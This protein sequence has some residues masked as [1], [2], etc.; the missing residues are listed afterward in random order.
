MV[1]HRNLK[2]STIMTRVLM[3]DCLARGKGERRA[4]LDVVGVGPRSIVGVLER[5][6]IESRIMVFEELA[7]NPAVMLEYDVLMVSAMSSDKGCAFKALR[8]WKEFGR[9]PTIIGGPIGEEYTLL[10]EKGFDLVVVGEGEKVVEKLLKLGLRDSILPEVGI[11]KEIQGL[12]FKHNDNVVFTGRGPRLSSHDL[13]FYRPST[14]RIIDYPSYWGLRIYV[15]V[16]RGCSNFYRPKIKFPSGVKCIDCDICRSGELRQRLTCPVN[17]PP[18]CGYCSVPALY[19][20]SR[21]KPIDAVYREV[22]ELIELGATR[23]VLS[24][25]DFLDYGRDWLVEPDPLTDPRS[26]PPNIDAI[27]NLLERLWNISEVSSGE[28]AI[29]I[30]NIKANLVNEEVASLLGEYLKGTPVHIG[31]ETGSIEH[32]LAIGRP[33]TPNECIKAVELLVKHGLRP[34]LYFIHGLPGQTLDTAYETIKIMEEA[35]S[36]GAEKITVYRFSP[37]PGTAFEQFPPGPPAH[38]NPASSLIYSKATELNKMYKNRLIGKNIEA[39]VV[40]RRGSYGVAYPFYHGPVILV[41]DG[42]RF[43]GYLAK[44]K[45]TKVISD[46]LVEG[47]VLRV[48]RRIEKTSI[49]KR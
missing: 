13:D 7:A 39:V 1:K 15:E 37:L 40:G 28:V 23:I 41:N 45:I 31:C 3:I 36:K 48:I 12:A 34:Y 25:P 9:G 21:S 19:G 29:M 38:S 5:F 22:K 14:K 4:T 44:I 35:F 32:A 8:Y 11:L 47:R 2:R 43:R 26:P 49:S 46:R 27:K 30:E 42:I 16:V 24:G 17:I 33:S 6:N 10:I 20:P 18:G